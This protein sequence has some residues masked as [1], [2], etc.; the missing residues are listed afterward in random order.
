MTTSD[1]IFIYYQMFYEH[2]EKQSRIGLKTAIVQNQDI[3][4]VVTI[5]IKVLVTHNWYQLLRMVV[6]ELDSKWSYGILF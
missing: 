3:D 6:F 4:L 1:L 2:F 5:K